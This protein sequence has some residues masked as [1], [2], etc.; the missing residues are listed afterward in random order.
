MGAAPNT[1]QPPFPPYYGGPVAPQPRPFPLP[2]IDGP[3]PRPVAPPPPQRPAPRP[4]P[5]PVAPPPP[6]KRPAPLPGRPSPQLPRPLPIDQ[7]GSPIFAPLP[8]NNFVDRGPYRPSPPSFD[9]RMIQQLFRNLMNDY[10]ARINA[11]RDYNY[12]FQPQPTQPT[13][14]RPSG[15]DFID[16]RDP[17]KKYLTNMIDYIDPVT[18]ETASRTNG[19]VPGP[20]SR[21]VPVGQAGMFNQRPPQGPQVG[22]GMGELLPQRPNLIPQPGYGIPQGPQNAQDAMSAYNNLLQQG[23]QRSNTLNQDAASNFAN[24][25][26]G[27]PTTQPAIPS[28]GMPAAGFGAQKPKAPTPKPTQGFSNIRAF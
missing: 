26:A 18:G 20:G 5:R 3:R 22:G 14:P 13:Q 19:I 2:P 16:N 21:F 8:P 27:A 23:I 10:Y 6:P 1:P 7:G 28:M 24:L 11:E 17:N 9:E 4:A 12:S 15:P 25:Q